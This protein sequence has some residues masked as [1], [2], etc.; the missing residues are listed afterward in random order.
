MLRMVSEQYPNNRIVLGIEMEN[1]QADNNAERK[2]R[3]D[4][5]VKNGYKS[6][7]IVLESK[8]VTFKILA[9]G[10]AC[11]YEDFRLMNKKYIGIFASI[12]IKPKLKKENY[13]PC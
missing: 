12:F 3:K 13:I 4:F 5:Y 11:T 7:G 9:Y 10:G 1:E 8:G 2:A 6:S